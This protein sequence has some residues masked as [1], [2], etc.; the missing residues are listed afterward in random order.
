MSA[1]REL[2]FF[3]ARVADQAERHQDVV[4]IITKLANEDPNL[5]GDERNLLSVAYK[6]LTSSRRNA[7]RTVSAFLEDD[8]IKDIPERNNQLE[9]LKTKLLKEL[10]D[11]C[12]QLI[13]MVDNKLLPVANNAATKVFYEKLK[14]DYYR[15]SVEFKTEESERSKGSTQAR[16]SYERAM[17]VAKAEL[18]KAN[19][20][21][22]GLALNYSVFLYEIDGKKN[23]A[24]TLADETF[25]NAV[26]LLDELPED[27]YSEATMVLQLLKDNVQLWNEEIDN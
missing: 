1:D 8:A 20:Q 2:K 27:D 4:D 26:G 22:L 10:D 11:L 6:A 7:I 21:F 14:A 3:M 9:A 24:I 19:P 23:E 12:M 15:Y 16:A 13:N 17:E 25:K 5:T 18:A